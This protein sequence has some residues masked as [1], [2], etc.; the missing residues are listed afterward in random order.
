M[1]ENQNTNIAII[2]D[3][4]SIHKSKVVKEFM[5]SNNIKSILNLPYCPQYNA[6]EMLWALA[7]QRFR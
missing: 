3:N 6:I 4:A 2:W 1:E 7:K 5:E